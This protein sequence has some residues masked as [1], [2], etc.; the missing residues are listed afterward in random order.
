MRET[1]FCSTH[2]SSIFFAFSECLC[3][4]CS[5]ARVDCVEHTSMHSR[6]IIIIATASTTNTTV[7]TDVATAIIEND[8]FLHFGFL[9]VAAAVVP[10]ALCFFFV[11]VS[12]SSHYSSFLQSNTKH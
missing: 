12:T 2:V 7:T 1:R 9:A 8:I 10:T 5:F 4:C 3:V 6:H 11:V